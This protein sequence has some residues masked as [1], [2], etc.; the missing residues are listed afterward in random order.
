[1]EI[2]LRIKKVMIILLAVVVA[3]SLMP[4]FM[5]QKVLAADTNKA[6]INLSTL[7]SGSSSQPGE[8]GWTYNSGNGFLTL[9]EDGIYNLFGNG[10]GV[11]LVTAS[12]EQIAPTIILKDSV[13]TAPQN[14][15]AI[16]RLNSGTTIVLE[17]NN[18]INGS[19]MQAIT[20][21]GILNISGSGTINAK[22]VDTGTASYGI[23]M[24]D[25]SVL[26]INDNAT[27][28]ADGKRSGISVGGSDGTAQSECEIYV[29]PQ[30]EL[31]ASGDVNGISSGSSGIDNK[32]LKL[33]SD[34]ITNI[35]SLGDCGLLLSSGGTFTVTGIGRVTIQGATDYP[36]VYTDK[37]IM[38]GNNVLLTLQNG[39][40]MSEDH[41]FEKMVK[42]S[43]FVWKLGGSAMMTPILG[44]PPL[45]PL[46]V[47]SSTESEIEVSIPNKSSG[48][49]SL[50]PPP[51]SENEFSY[52]TKS[53]IYNA[54]PQGVS[55]TPK[56]GISG[57]GKINT[58]YTG[59]G[60]TNYKKSMVAPTNAGTY[61]IT[62]DVTNG[63]NYAASN[64]IL[65]GL[66]TIKKADISKVD[67]SIANMAW[68][69]KKL[70]PKSFTFN[71]VKHGIGS[72]T[73]HHGEVTKSG[74][75]KNIGKGSITINGKGNFTGKKVISFKI[76]PQKPA[77]PSILVG[78]KL[79]S[80]IWKGYSKKHPT[81]NKFEIRYRVTNTDKWKTKSVSTKYYDTTIMNLKKN[82]T[83]EVQIRSYKT[84]K[85]KKHYS[86]WS[87]PRI[88][89]KIK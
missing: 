53:T 18:T 86:G 40:D 50:V 32:S 34:G 19:N 30:A 4:G 15:P 3:V 88:S 10:S 26:N 89:Q 67:I 61:N 33:R 51:A 79:M 52:S 71:N 21:D 69:G 85:G 14:H 37:N 45:P 76:V 28:T 17:G 64:N 43:H 44:P 47:Y 73:T 74:A 23:S 82:K 7:S 8:A 24:Y 57:L 66:F 1:M 38:M 70:T 31:C 65:L 59:T 49:I 80:I 22:G 63:T 16:D 81:V 46:S 54:K 72:G 41:H 42:T 9:Q 75:N 12:S 84:I 35:F 27:V 62:V 83:Y 25:N 36:A 55:V 78:N 60:T 48:S 29:S 11:C 13:I 2:R 56:S 87:A 5:A 6:T 77:K 20:V 58:Y 39:A 68:S